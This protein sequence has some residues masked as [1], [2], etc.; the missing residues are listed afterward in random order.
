M[1]QSLLNSAERHTKQS[2]S[3]YAFSPCDGTKGGRGLGRTGPRQGT[4]SGCVA[5]STGARDERGRLGAS[6]GP[7]QAACKE[8]H[9]GTVPTLTVSLMVFPSSNSWKWFTSLPNQF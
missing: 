1:D 5:P 3:S 4:G 9:G 8:T 6:L 2:K 7:E